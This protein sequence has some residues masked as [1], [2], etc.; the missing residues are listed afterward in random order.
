[1]YASS[2]ILFLQLHKTGCSHITKLLR[3]YDG[4]ETRGKH[5]TLE[6]IGEIGDRTV[7]TSIRNPWDWYVSL[8]AYGCSGKG[9]MFLLLGR[10]PAEQATESLINFK[11]K[12]NAYLLFR[13]IGSVVSRYRGINQ[14]RH[15][16]GDPS[17]KALFQEWIKLVLGEWGQRHLP[18]GYKRSEARSHIGFYSYRHLKLVS[19]GTEFNSSDRTFT[20]FRPI[21][22]FY[23]TRKLFDEAIKMESLESDLARVLGNVGI[24]VTPE[25]LR[26]FGKTNTSE[27]SNYRS[28]YDSE[29]SR[30]VAERERLIIDEFGYEF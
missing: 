20:D 19:P 22:Q 25:E 21:K 2:R 13:E 4:G 14:F 23:Q 24:S 7:L 26:Q 9:T 11:K 29:S 1:M 18:D 12:R 5:S 27:R 3:H 28:Y 16:Y 15:M 10:S 17:D 6:E 30:L 8:W